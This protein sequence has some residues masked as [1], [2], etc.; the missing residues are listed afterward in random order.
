MLDLSRKVIIAIA[1]A[2]RHGD[3]KAERHGTDE[4]FLSVMS[5]EEIA[6]DVIECAREGA[7]IVH[8]HVRDKNGHLTE[9]LTEFSRTVAMIKEKCDVIVE[10]ST[11]GVSELSAQERSGVLNLPDVEVAAL[12]MGSVN[13][14]EAAFVNEPADICMWAKMMLER[15]VMPIMECFEPGM[16]ETVAVLTEEQVLRKPYVYGICLGFAG[17]QPARTVNLQHMANLMPKDAVWYYQ[18]H[19][20]KDLS[21]MA[22]AIAAGAKIVRVGFEDSITYAPGKSG[23]TNAELV[24]KIAELIRMIG[25]EVA[26]T[27]QAREIIGLR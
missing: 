3:E 22:A 21:I 18:Q 1:P 16:L 25:F 19:G 9:D 14:G 4:V 26:T 5:P 13:L 24:K 7:S 12:N 17:T 2:A 23:K 10:G 27:A 15:K 8:M 11:G 20:M 6:G